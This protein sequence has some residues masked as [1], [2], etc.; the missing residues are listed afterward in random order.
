MTMN[1][2]TLQPFEDGRL[3]GV[4]LANGFIVEEDP[5]YGRLIGYED[6]FGLTQQV[7]VALALRPGRLRGVEF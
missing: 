6:I 3:V 1:A 7:A 4:S 2:Q 5:D